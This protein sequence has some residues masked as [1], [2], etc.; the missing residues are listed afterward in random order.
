MGV[1][2]GILPVSAFLALILAPIIILAAI[3]ARRHGHLRSRAAIIAIAAIIG[4]LIV[5]GM[6]LG[7]VP[8]GEAAG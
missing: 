3:Y 2:V 7:L 1:D 4:L 8:T 6:G 5:F